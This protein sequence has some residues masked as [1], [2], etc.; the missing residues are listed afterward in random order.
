MKQK[1][2]RE[3]LI[4][5]ALAVLLTFAAASFIFYGLFRE[6]IMDDLRDDARLLQE[7]HVF[8]NVE[9]VKE[10]E[11]IL[12]SE[13][14]RITVIDREGRVVF[15]SRANEQEMVSHENRP[16]VQDAFEY[17]EGH[18]TRLSETLA[19]SLFYYAVRLENG[20]VLRI[21]READSLFAVLRGLLPGIACVLLLLFVFCILLSGWF[22]KSLVRP[23]EKMAENISGP[24][25][26]A[27]Y[28]ELAPFLAKIRQQHADILKN[29]QVRQ[30]FTANVSHELKTPLT[31]ISGYAE[32]IEHGMAGEEN[33]RQFA[34]EIHRNASR[35]L[36]LINDIIRLSELDSGGRKLERETV[37]LYETAAECLD[38]LRLNA[39]RQN[40][41]LHLYGEAV[42]IYADRQLIEELIYNLCDNA[43]RYNNRGGSVSVTAGRE[44]RQPFL[45]VA[46]TGIGI[47]AEHQDRI[48]ERFYRV[49]KSRS[50]ETGGTGLGLA[51]VKHIASRHDANILLESEEGKGTKIRVVFPEISSP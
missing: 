10:S 6:Q 36:T 7:M 43:I 47:S 38:M 40:V 13:N 30:E 32:L 26:E 5:S 18:H 23:I 33:T 49:D 4:A 21:S 51:I 48:F 50:R 31:S 34:A 44:G 46:D 28:K 42:T 20:N 17:G 8:D 16:E 29:A 9:S 11:D 45:E 37:E 35:L 41:S 25:A 22:T 1:I 15:D 2:H 12:K 24:G 39:A 27:A 3:L 14:L 19:R